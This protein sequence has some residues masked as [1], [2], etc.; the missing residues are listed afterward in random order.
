MPAEFRIFRLVNATH[1]AFPDLGENAV[2]QQQPL[3][4]D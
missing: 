3:W 2:M 1:T 4:F